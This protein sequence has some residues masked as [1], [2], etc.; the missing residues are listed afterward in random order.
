V[1]EDEPHGFDATPEQAL[2][3]AESLLDRR[4]L[5]HA[6][7]A[8]NFAELRG[9][10]PDLC[11]SGRWVAAMLRGDFP[12]AWRECDAIRKRGAPDPNRF[13]QGEDIRGKRVILRCLHGFGD[14]VQFLRYAPMLRALASKLI[15]EVPPAMLEIASCFD[16]VEEVITWGEKAPRMAPEWEV[17]IEI[18]ELP[19][20]FRT[21]LEDLPI[22]TN[23]LHIPESVLRA[24]APQPSSPESLRV[25]MVWASGE[26]NPTRSVPFELLWILTN[27]SGCEFWNVQGGP[28]R[29]EWQQL[30]ASPTLHD[31]YSSSDTI[32]K[33]AGLI[34][35]LDLVITP[36]TLAAHLAGALNTPAWVLLE[37]ASDWRWMHGRTDCPWY[38][39]LRLFRQPAAG[40]WRGAVDQVRAALRALERQHAQTERLVA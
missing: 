28:P 2:R 11:S 32:L 30:A 35:Q 39:S 17:Q 7:P 23:Y 29:D 10:S 31:A 14:A 15:V 24:V 18:V 19:Y 37:H 3:Y 6:V 38:P 36:D 33:L 5:S 16:G 20:V 4:K 25:G 22:A 9:A 34:A 1:I 21:Q 13:W 8:L 27:T 12:A 26:W 40:N